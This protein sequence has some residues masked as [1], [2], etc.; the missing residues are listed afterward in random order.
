MRVALARALARDPAVLLLDE[1]FGAVD[2][3]VRR[4]LIALVARLRA[5]SAVPM[6]LVTHDLD[7]AAGIADLAAFMAD[8]RVVETGPAPALLADPGCALNHWRCS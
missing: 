3:P 1:P 7:E 5:R 2:R 8:G 4:A 6:I